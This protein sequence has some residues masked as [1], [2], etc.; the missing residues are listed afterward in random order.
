[1][2]L[3]PLLS[4]LRHCVFE[5]PMLE[6]P[7][8]RRLGNTDVPSP[9][10]KDFGL[11]AESD[12]DRISAIAVLLLFRAP[13][14]IALRVVAIIVQALKGS[15]LW[16]PPHVGIKVFESLPSL[17]DSDTARS[18]GIESTRF[19][20]LASLTHQIPSVVFGCVA[21]SVLTRSPEGRF[22]STGSGV[23]ITE[24][25][26]NNSHDSTARTKAFPPRGGVNVFRNAA[27]RCEFS[28]LITDLNSRCHR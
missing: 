10:G 17:A 12:S 27:N 18:I 1:M 16:P 26:R 3:S 19:R 8:H 24:G 9:F 21:K 2:N 23:A 22:A 6:A 20:V 4:R 14:A 15:A 7:L 25:A 13:Y 11:S 5:R 28:E